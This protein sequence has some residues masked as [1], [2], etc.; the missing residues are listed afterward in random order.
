VTGLRRGVLLLAVVVA[1]VLAGT[2]TA[3]QAAFD[4]EASMATLTVGTTTVLAPTNVTVETS[5][6]KARWVDVTVR[7][8]ASTTEKVTGYQV[9]AHRSDGVVQV[10]AQTDA[11]TTSVSGTVD[12]FTLTGYTTTL[13]V[14][15]RT[16]YG[17]TAVSAQTGTV[18]C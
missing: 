10:V 9:T 6:C 11:A 12:K 1:T 15:A 2:A 14:M 4:D 3:A 7:W 13:T 16:S 8:G 17:W 5:G 18:R